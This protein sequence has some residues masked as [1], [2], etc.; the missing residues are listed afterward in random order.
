VAKKNKTA[1]GLKWKVPGIMGGNAVPGW[2]DQQ[3]SIVRRIVLFLFTKAV[4]NVDTLIPAKLLDE[5][6]ALLLKCNKAYLQAVREVQSR[7]IWSVLPQYF[8]TT[9]DEMAQVVNSMR[10]FLA[11][12]AVQLG[13]DLFCP[14]STV[15][16]EWAKFIADLN[17]RPKP[18]WNSDLYTGPM[19]SKG[20]SVVTQNRTYRGSRKKQLYVL[21]MDVTINMGADE[22][23]SPNAQ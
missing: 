19:E 1:T 23:S 12:D 15:R 2:E 16:G 6:P 7:S 4:T 9:R 13:T 17:I 3:G 21:G 18:T 10:G 22:N 14:I 11:S 8:H 20:L 5:M